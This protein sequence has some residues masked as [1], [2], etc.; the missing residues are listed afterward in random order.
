[1]NLIKKINDSVLLKFTTA[2]F[3]LIGI[4]TLFFLWNIKNTESA[5]LNSIYQKRKNYIV[6]ETRETAKKILDTRI[7]LIK[8][9]I[10][11]HEKELSYALFTVDREK[12]V[13]I[14]SSLAVFPCVKG[15]ILYDLMTDKPF[16][17]AEK[18]QNEK[19]SYSNKTPD[20]RN[21]H[22]LSIDLLGDDG[23]KLGYLKILYDASWLTKE[24][25]RLEHE[26]MEALDRE[27]AF[28]ENMLRDS[29]KQ[30]LFSLL[31]I[32]AALYTAFYILFA[33]IIYE[34]IRQ[35]EN[36]LKNFFNTLT[37]KHEQSINLQEIKTND[38]FGRM[39]KFIN[40]GIIASINIHQELA[41]HAQE[42]SKLA[43]VLEQSAQSI[44]I[45]DLDGK[46]EYVNPAF[47]EIT[48]YSFEEVRGENPRFMKSGQHPESFYKELWQTISAGKNWEG[49]FA[50]RRKNG[51]IYYER[52]IIFPVKDHKGEIINFA[53]AKQDITKER[54]LE[55]QLR[56]TQKMESIGL[57]AGGVAHDFNNLLTVINGLAEL[58]LL[59]AD[60]DNPLRNDF[61]AI[62]N[63]GRKAQVLTSQLLAFSRKQAYTPRIIDINRTLGSME[64]IVRRLIDEDIQIRTRLTGGLPKIKADASQIEQI[65]INLI[66]NARDAL[67]AINRTGFHKS[68]RIETGMADP[69]TTPVSDCSE[70]LQGQSYVYFSVSD[71]GIG[72]DEATQQRIFEPFFTTKEKSRGTGLGLAMIYGIVKQ[73]GGTIQVHS[74]SGQG[75]TFTIC[76]PVAKAEELEQAR[77]DGKPTTKTLQGCETILLVEDEESVREFTKKTLASLGYRV[78]IA[79][80]GAVAL[81]LLQNGLSPDLIITDI[82]MPVMNGW[83]FADRALAINP[84]QKI[85]YLSG[86]ADDHLTRFEKSDHDPE[87][88]NKPFSIRELAAIVRKVLEQ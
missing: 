53:A 20:T 38:E 69:E 66:I 56:Q 64:K 61:D 63:A 30:Q 72:M 81:Q 28:A 2:I 12:I 26:D 15:V 17:T 47:E 10:L 68:I 1:M 39:G 76:W 8:T 83:E 52:S 78:Y 79:E 50:N 34:P 75:T 57:L 19:F 37:G 29:L 70:E 44:L 25:L 59:S 21:L 23:K 14:I 45:T 16:I 86:Y 3:G 54:D 35:L 48:G 87:L 51:T 82:V 84:E 7:S 60:P 43:T 33:K 88:I 73:N 27:F 22:S 49:I 74:K 58:A 13:D 9:T 32:F 62:L 40:S 36:N 24:V 67:N 11:A 55:H 85:I 46:I 77:P 6:R 41:R 5:L 80:N 42:V 4:F 71:N 65:L 18:L 31:L